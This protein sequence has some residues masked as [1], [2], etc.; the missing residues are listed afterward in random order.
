MTRACHCFDVDAPAAAL[1]LGSRILQGPL[2]SRHVHVH[3]LMPGVAFRSLCLGIVFEA[4]FLGRG[5]VGNCLAALMLSINGEQSFAASCA[6]AAG[7]RARK[8]TLPFLESPGN[9][10]HDRNTGLL[11]GSP[12]L[13][14]GLAGRIA[15]HSAE[16]Q[17]SLLKVLPSAR[18]A[19]VGASDLPSSSAGRLLLHLPCTP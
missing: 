1:F 12:P 14:C 5:L 15:K 7:N 6:H 8:R 10:G 16:A 11:C 2:C 4:M 9:W 17:T 3:P 19:P 13:S 18:T